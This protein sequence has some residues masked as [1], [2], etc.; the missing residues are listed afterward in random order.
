VENNIDLFKSDLPESVEDEVTKE[1]LFHM[2]ATIKKVTEDI[3]RYQL[4][5][6]VAAMMEYVNNLYSIEKKLQDGHKALFRDAVASLVKLI[7]PFT[8][9]AAE[10]LWEMADMGELISRSEWPSFDEKFIQKDEITIAVQV[11]GKL[12]G[13]I[14]IPVDMDKE[15]VFETALANENVSKHTEGKDFIK[16]IYVPKKLVNFVVK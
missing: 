5:T 8:P 13:Q 1:I 9:H 3:E 2:H 4:N 7:A 10:E 6:A 11:N 15:S 12:R 16:K 14:E